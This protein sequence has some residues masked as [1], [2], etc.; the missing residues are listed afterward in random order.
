MTAVVE[1]AGDRV[2]RCDEQLSDWRNL[3]L[4]NALNHLG[5]GVFAESEIFNEVFSWCGVR[6]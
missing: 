3:I 2:P 5:R 6:R 4:R 1:S